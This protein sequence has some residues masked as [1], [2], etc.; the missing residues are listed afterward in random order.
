MRMQVIRPFAAAV[1]RWRRGS[2]L[3]PGE[4]YLLLLVF[5]VYSVLWVGAGIWLVQAWD[6]IGWLQRVAVSVG[7]LVVSPTLD[8]LFRSYA[9]Y[10]ALHEEGKFGA[11][12]DPPPA[13]ADGQPG[14]PRPQS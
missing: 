9:K 8:D 7:L 12:V 3:G 11:P 1:R 13:P 2:L 4:Y 5:W 10:R 6:R 14:N